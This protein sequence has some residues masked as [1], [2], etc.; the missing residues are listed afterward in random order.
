MVAITQSSRPLRPLRSFVVAGLARLAP[1]LALLLLLGCHD[2]PSEPRGEVS[3]STLSKATLSGRTG[4]LLREV[5]HDEARYD[6]VWRELWNGA[7]DKPVVDFQSEMVIVA[8]SGIPCFG[9]VV[10]EQVE[11]ERSAVLIRMADSTP[12]SLCLCAAEEYTFHVVRATRVDGEAFFS[13]RPIPPT[14]PS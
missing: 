13:V 11:R 6:A 4:P 5:I 7:G 3:L 8:T 2:S 14:C 12:G 10:I 1:A 9:N